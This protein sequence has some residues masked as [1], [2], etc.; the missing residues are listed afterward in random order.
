MPAYATEEQFRHLATRVDILER[1]VEGE[2]TVTRYILE[3]TRRNGDDLAA[4]KTRLDRVEN[5]LDGVERRL[6]ALEDRVGALER[7]FGEFVRTFPSIVG[8]VVREALRERDGA[9]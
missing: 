4:V 5:R 3:Q 6:G 9:N 2:K 1:E 7:Q 8:E